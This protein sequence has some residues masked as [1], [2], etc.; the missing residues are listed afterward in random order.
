MVLAY[1]LALKCIL[2]T[3]DLGSWQSP[4]EAG[5]FEGFSATIFTPLE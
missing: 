2:S 3:L 5:M 4:P 1:Q